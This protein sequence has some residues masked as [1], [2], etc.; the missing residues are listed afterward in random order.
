MNSVYFNDTVQYIANN[1]LNEG[2]II[3]HLRNDNII[4][5][6][7]N[8]L[9]ISNNN[10]KNNNNDNNNNNNNNNTFIQ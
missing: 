8:R 6:N 7:N 2:I 10:K 9:S 3:R 1:E 4:V 5:K